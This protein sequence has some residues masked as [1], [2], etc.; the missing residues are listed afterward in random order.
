LLLSREGI[1]AIYYSNIT[2]VAITDIKTSIFIY[3]LHL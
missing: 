2:K 1:V 3:S